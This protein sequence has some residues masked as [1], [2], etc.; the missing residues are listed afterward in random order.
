MCIINLYHVPNHPHTLIPR[1]LDKNH[2]ML[3][4]GAARFSL[5]L[6]ADGER[7]VQDHACS[8]HVDNGKPA[9]GRLRVCTH[10]IFFEPELRSLPILRVPFNRMQQVGERGGKCLVLANE[11]T[12]MKKSGRD[13]PYVFV[14]HPV[15]H[16]F[17]LDHSTND[18]LLL[19]IAELFRCSKDGSSPDHIVSRYRDGALPFKLS[20]LVD[21]NEEILA[22]CICNRIKPFILEECRLVLTTKRLYLQPVDD[23]EG[24]TQVF[25]LKKVRQVF[26]RRHALRE[27]G[28]EILMP[29]KAVFVA[30][31]SMSER[32]QIYTVLFH[33]P[34]VDVALDKESSD[35]V[36]A[37]WVRGDMSNYDYLMY[38]N[39]LAGRTKNDMAQYPVF[40]WILTDYTSSSIDLSDA[41][42]YRDLSKPV[43]AL[44]PQRLATF[45]ER[46]AEMPAD[47]QE[48]LYGTHYST[49]GYVLFYLVRKRPELMLRLQNGKFDAPDRSFY[50]IPQTWQSCYQSSTD[51]KELIPE[52]FSDPSILENAQNLELGERQ[53]GARVDDVE[54]PPW[55]RPND[56]KRFMETHR[57]ALESQHVS[58][59]LHQWIDLIFGSKQ[60]GA[61]AKQADN[62][63]YPLTYQGSIDVE[64]VEDEQMRAS[65][66][67][68]ISEFG[69]TPKQVFF[70][71]HPQRF[72]SAAILL[73]VLRI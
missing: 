56:F 37:K 22:D 32:D 13:Y 48:F 38:I 5:L 73:R 2:G 41:S 35:A 7:Y 63:F 39:N 54:L 31:E 28:L 49:P 61:E 50:S 69:Q 3:D 27:I 21:W 47:G 33:H 10:S 9:R 60:R 1:W 20:N 36:M 68:Q 64:S 23:I 11:T 51:L 70:K 16:V 4:R 72:S 52:F 12:E 30:F 14:A 40:P 42:I 8:H 59:N 17:S 46:L 53:N 45:K 62:L 26:R 57:E 19:C 43:G 34:V 25:E 44:N 67:L 66:E 24:S 15:T 6:L 55:C 71:P 65:Y 18:D 58:A 29:K